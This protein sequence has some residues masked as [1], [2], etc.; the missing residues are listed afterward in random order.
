[1]K[2]A[3]YAKERM[4]AY[5]APCFSFVCVVNHNQQLRRLRAH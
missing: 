1:M 3:F 2:A 5:R 4:G